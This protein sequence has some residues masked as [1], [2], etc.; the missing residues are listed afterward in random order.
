MAIYTVHEPPMTRPEA[1]RGPERFA[2]VRDGFH[3]WAFVLT[4]LWLLWRRL[5]LVFF[6]YLILCAAL[7]FGMRWLGVPT[8]AVALMQIMLSF[9]VGLEAGTL[10]RWT[11]R[12]RKWSEV[13]VVSA[14]NIEEAERRFFDGWTG[15]PQPASDLGERPSSFL[16]PA[17][18]VAFG[19][20]PVRTRVAQ[21]SDVV[22]LFPEPG[23][24]R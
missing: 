2:V 17:G 18:S 9:L 6:G 5:W 7:A 14:R 21:S 19:R 12:R 23:A 13:G 15:N 1:R 11:L 8:G 22:G 16:P 24:Q 20:L 4:P 10:W 3:F